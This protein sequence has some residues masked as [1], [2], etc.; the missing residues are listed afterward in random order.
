MDDFIGALVLYL[1]NKKP[2]MQLR[3]DKSCYEKN[4]TR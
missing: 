4:Y 3:L 1:D 2:D